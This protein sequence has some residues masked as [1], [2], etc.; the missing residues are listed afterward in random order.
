VLRILSHV[1]RLEAI[2]LPPEIVDRVEIIP[3]PMEGELSE[4][5][6]GEVL[7]TS[8]TSVP[9]LA[10]A[11]SR[12]VRWVHLI[13]TGI[14][15]FPV[16]L[17]GPDRI[18]TNSRGLSAVPI[19]EW[20]MACMLA[21]EK[22][23]PDAWIHERPERWNIPASPLG[24]LHD[25]TLALLGLGGIGSAVAE[26]SLP[27]AMRVKAMRRSDGPSPVEGVEMVR[28]VTELVADADHVVLVAPLTDATR[29]IVDREL[30]SAMKP[31]VHLVNV[32]RGPIV[33]QDDLRVALDDGTVAMAS[34]D[35]T[36]PE[37]LPPGHWLYDHPRVRLSPHTSWSFPGAFPA[38][39]EVFA[40]NLGR[41]LDD[42]PLL[43]VV[44]PADGY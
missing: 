14:D 5:L 1:G 41:Y 7:L 33:V 3:I 32:A 6:T 28:S 21:F 37:P 38:M 35:T 13:G 24:T 23:L 17:I 30:F 2:T 42:R 31:G 25:K 16:D 20:V 9:N 15:S 10:D 4:G 8:P 18:L 36:D 11:L 43:S 12:G 40:E 29:G 34:L 26:R 39:F 22:R 27:F 44:D 19:S